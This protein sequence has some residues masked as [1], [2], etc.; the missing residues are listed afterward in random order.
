MVVLAVL[1]C[2]GSSG[3]CG[4]RGCC[5]PCCRRPL[6]PGT[7]AEAAALTTITRVFGSRLVVRVPELLRQPSFRRFWTA[8]SISY[9]EDQ[10]TLIALPLVAVPAVHAT[11]AEVGHLATA[12]MLPMLVLGVHA[13]DWVDRAGRRRLVLVSADAARVLLLASIPVADAL[14]VLN[15]V[16]LYCVAA[17]SG[18]AA[19]L[20]DVGAA[21]VVP[22]LVPGG[23][24]MAGNFCGAVTPSP[25]WPGRAWAGFSSS[26]SPPRSPL[27]S[28]RPRSWH[29]RRSSPSLTS[30]RPGPAA[31]HREEP[32]P[33]CASSSVTRFSGPT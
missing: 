20:F 27:S 15:M 23:Q 25:G 17:L 12:A 14:G 8:Q 19:V 31:A 26:S 1:P 13:G 6:R 24:R 4:R 9:L 3:G 11:T 32:P 5:P 29:R 10:V 7:L 16:Q 2:R 30:R 33:G 22:A 28:T 21:S 18:V